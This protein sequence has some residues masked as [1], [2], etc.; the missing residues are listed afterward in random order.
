MV[1][2]NYP[3]YACFDGNGNGIHMLVVVPRLVWRLR[4]RKR[5]LSCERSGDLRLLPYLSLRAE[6]TIREQ[7]ARRSV[8]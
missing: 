5:R 6:A 8:G 3:P 7:I 4:E 2:S 1:T